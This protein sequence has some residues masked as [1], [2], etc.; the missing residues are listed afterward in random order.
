MKLARFR[1]SSVFLTLLISDESVFF[2]VDDFVFTV[3]NL[4]SPEFS[5]VDAAF[6][7]VGATF[8]TVDTKFSTDGATFS[9][10]DATFSTV[11]AAFRTSSN[12][13]LVLFSI[14]C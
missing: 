3:L 9:T 6:S 2:F 5:T 10:V 11:C 8:S 7:T 12:D 1:D 14:N 13:V 4:L